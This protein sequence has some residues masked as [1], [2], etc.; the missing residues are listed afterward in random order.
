MKRY[1]DKKKVIYKTFYS[2]LLQIYLSIKLNAKDILEIGKG[3][4]FVSS[5]LSQYCNLTTLDFKED[6][7]FL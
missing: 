5:V 3:Y 2:H 7:I 4:G 6:F 1:N